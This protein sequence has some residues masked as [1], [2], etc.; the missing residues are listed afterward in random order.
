[1]LRGSARGRGHALLDRAL[2]LP[3]A[4]TDD[5]DRC[6]RGGIPDERRF[7]TTPQRAKAM[8]HRALAAGMPAPGVT[9]D[10]VYGDDRRRRLWREAQ[11]HAYGLAV[12]G[13]EYVWRDGDQRQVKTL[14]APLPQD[15]WT[16]LSAGDGAKGPRWDD[17]CWRPLAD[18]MEPTWRRW[19]LVRR[20]ISEPTPRR[21]SVT[22]APQDTILG[23]V[24]RVAGTRWS[25]EQ[26][27]EAAKGE[28]GLDHDEVRSWT[29]G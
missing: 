10:R 5:R 18:P 27:F 29:G 1:V 22:Y 7:A 19:R 2:S 4:W 20:R 11:P 16:R 13:K 12:S 14:W 3:Q 17:G 23:E 24:V 28:V 25:M 26:L 15:G 9:G 6:R 8:R 21:A